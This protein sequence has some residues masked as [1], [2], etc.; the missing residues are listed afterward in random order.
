MVGHRENF[1][2]M[3]LPTAQPSSTSEISAVSVKEL[4]Q[5]HNFHSLYNRRTHLPELIL[6]VK[7]PSHDSIHLQICKHSI[8]ETIC[9]PQIRKNRSVSVTI[10]TISLKTHSYQ[11][12]YKCT[13]SWKR[14]NVR[15]GRQLMLQRVNYRILLQLSSSLVMYPHWLFSR[16]TEH[17]TVKFC[18]IISLL[19][20]EIRWH[21]LQH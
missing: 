17:I 16:Q 13:Y 10:L 2:R 1:R 7:W 9:C 21:I 20:Q 5:K 8:S 15:S 4:E 18:M 11:T 6:L 12:V 3:L 14:P 19:S